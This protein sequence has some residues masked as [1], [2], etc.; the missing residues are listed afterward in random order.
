MKSHSLNLYICNRLK[1][2]ERHLRAYKVG[3]NPKTLNKL[4]VDIKK[5][6]AV[7]S[8]IKDIYD[9]SNRK[10]VLQPLFKNAGKIRELQININL[11]NDLPHPPKPLI[12]QLEKS[13]LIFIRQFI[14]NISDYTNKVKN[15][16]DF[17][18]LPSSLPKNKIIKKYFKKIAVKAKKM[19]RKLDRS[20]LHLFRKKIKKI[21][22][23]YNALPKK[24]QV[25]KEV[26]K[27]KINEMQKRVGSWHDTYSAIIFLSHHRILDKKK[28]ILALKEK[29]KK[30]FKNLYE[31]LK[32]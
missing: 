17:F 5:I 28:Y 21:L 31:K 9:F 7:F 32:K 10:K 23:S 3:E 22:Y 13:E 25:V 26:N 19:M 18:S 11:L 20:D 4:R 29:E 14:N 1:S 2:V 24:L 27:M 16:R 12:S 30:Q 15:Y 8:F 6:K